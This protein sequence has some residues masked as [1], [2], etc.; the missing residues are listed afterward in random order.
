MTAKGFARGRVHRSHSAQLKGWAQRARLEQRVLLTRRRAV[1]GTRRRSTTSLAETPT[2]VGLLARQSVAGLRPWPCGK[3]TGRFAE[4]SFPELS[5][6]P[7]IGCYIATEPQGSQVSGRPPADGRPAA[8]CVAGPAFTAK[9]AD[10]P[11]G[12]GASTARAGGADEPTMLKIFGRNVAT[13][14]LHHTAK[15]APL[16]AL[17]WSWN[18]GPFITSRAQAVPEEDFGCH[19]VPTLCGP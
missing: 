17:W 6:K 16:G 13:E 2:A 19:K 14:G 7:G 1:A 12:R 9:A 3:R 11:F 10:A 15:T 8:H 4:A 5:A 18:G